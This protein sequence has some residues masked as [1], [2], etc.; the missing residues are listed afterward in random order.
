MT[1]FCA[2]SKRRPRNVQPQVDRLEDLIAPSTIPT[3][4]PVSIGDISVEL[5]RMREKVATATITAT[6]DVTQMADSHPTVSVTLNSDASGSAL[7]GTATG[8]TNSALSGDSSPTQ[9]ALSGATGDA[10][11]T[12]TSTA[13]TTASKVDPT[14]IFAKAFSKP[15]ATSGLSGAVKAKLDA[16]S[17]LAKAIGANAYASAHATGGTSS[18]A[19]TLTVTSSTGAQSADQSVTSTQQS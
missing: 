16:A 11:A 1:S 14:S 18:N 2:S 8:G 7:G 5:T 13:T 19:L 15:S 10:S 4:P 3:I 12:G 6:Q 17:G 9:N